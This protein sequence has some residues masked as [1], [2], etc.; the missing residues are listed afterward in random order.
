MKEWDN[1]HPVIIV[2]TKYYSTPTSKFREMGVS[3]VIWANHNLRSSIKAMQETSKQIFEDQT[4]KFVED[5][6]VTVDE[7]FR[8]QGEDELRIAEK[9]TCLQLGVKLM[10]LF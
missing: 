5:N 9:N 6:V 4:L 7:V 8:I 1:R 3:T 2:P 10:R